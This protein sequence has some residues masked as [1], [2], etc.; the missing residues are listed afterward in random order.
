MVRVK[1][2]GVRIAG[3]GGVANQGTKRN[4]NNMQK[5]VNL[6]SYFGGKYP[7]LKW[8]INKFPAGN[9]HFIDIMCGS[10]NVALNVNYPLVTVNDVNNEI[11]NLFNV[12]RDNYDEFLRAL[13]FTPFSR[14]ELNRIITD[15]INGI[16]C[17]AVERARRYFVKSQLGFGAN[18]SQNDHYGCG[19]EW[20]LHETNFYRVDNWNLKLKRL[21]KITARLRQF[22]I[23]NRSAL[24]LFDNVNCPGNI[25]YF[26]PPYLLSLRKSKK[27]Y[28]HE[29]YNDFHRAIA[30]KVKDAKCFVAISGYDSPIYDEIFTGFYKSVDK[31]KRSNVG[32]IV[33]SECLWTNYNP[34][35]I[36][37]NLTLQFNE[38]QKLS[39]FDRTVAGAHAGTV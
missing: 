21:A 15:A 38:D 23:E 5:Y 28:R 31:P 22:Q 13:Y 1:R 9:Y 19:F 33:T 3:T 36:N 18:G 35:A 4:F 26:D 16:E 29:V 17:T 34:Y 39:R 7:H 10:G 24:D 20:V 30:E 27:R 12:L 25:V 8:L 14:A 2:Q 32:K 11:I 6:I 37:G